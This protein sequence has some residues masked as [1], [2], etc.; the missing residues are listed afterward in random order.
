M[1]DGE[2][3]DLGFWSSVCSESLKWL[4]SLNVKGCRVCVYFKFVATDSFALL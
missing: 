1:I 4:L 3:R 2:S